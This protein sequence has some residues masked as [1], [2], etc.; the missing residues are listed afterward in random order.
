[1]SDYLTNLAARSLDRAATVVQP[2]LALLFEPPQANASEPSSRETTSAGTHANDGATAHRA[3]LLS[4]TLS[5]PSPHESLSPAFPSH[6]TPPSV[7]DERHDAPGA[8]WSPTGSTRAPRTFQEAPFPSSAGQVDAEHGGAREDGLP[9]QTTSRNPE[10]SSSDAGLLIPPPASQIIPADSL[11]TAATHASEFHASEETRPPHDA[12]PASFK[13]THG[14]RAS[15]L[16]T[17][18]S[19]HVLSNSEPVSSATESM[20]PATRRTPGALD[21]DAQDASGHLLRQPLEDAARR[22]IVEQL[23]TRTDSPRRSPEGAAQPP[24][25]APQSLLVPVSSNATAPTA[26][27]STVL[28]GSETAATRDALRVQVRVPTPA[29]APASADAAAKPEAT[30]TIHVSI[31]RIEV[32]A[33]APPAPPAPPQPRPSPA[34]PAPQMSLDDYLRAHNGGRK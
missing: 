9:A 3:T 24:E 13:A 15:Q 16:S 12:A 10:P 18:T 8:K 4:G 17:P 2:R 28:H 34:R 7:E 29:P 27:S 20:R 5:S 6:T 14:E 19:S 11:E 31:G 21:S 23:S 30:P 26:A 1:M 32:R 33:V 25:S 22:A